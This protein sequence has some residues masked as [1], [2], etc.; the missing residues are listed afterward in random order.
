[1]RPTVCG[2]TGSESL[3]VNV[4]V[5]VPTAVGLNFTPIVQDAPRARLDPQVLVC[6]KSPLF[7]PAMLMLEMLNAVVPR[8]VKVT[9]LAALVVPTVRLAKVIVAGDTV[10]PVPVP[11]KLTVWGLPM[12]LS[13]T[14][15]AAAL[16]PTT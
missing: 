8:F 14:L 12:A 3:I 5:R 16:A 1:V 15:M 2:L 4:P 10:T 11:L 6:E 9:L 7:V 13:V